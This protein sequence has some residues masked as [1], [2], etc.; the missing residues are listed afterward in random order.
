MVKMNWVSLL[1]T[2][3]KDPRLEGGD[4]YWYTYMR[5]ERG[6]VS[7]CSIESSV[8]SKSCIRIVQIVMGVYPHQKDR[9][10]GSTSCLDSNIAGLAKEVCR[11]DPRMSI[12]MKVQDRIFVLHLEL[13]EA[14]NRTK[15]RILTVLYLT[16]RHNHNS[17]SLRW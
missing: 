3:L 4:N 9:V 10:F 6:A 2:V 11:M 14:S 16:M 13:N 17:G 5:L 7:E 8:V 12:S 15:E 1:S